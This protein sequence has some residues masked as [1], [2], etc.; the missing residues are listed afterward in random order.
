M[1]SL[2]IMLIKLMHNNHSF[3]R[4]YLF[5]I[6]LKI[7]L[8]LIINKI[9]NFIKIYS[10]VMKKKYKYIKN[11]EKVLSLLLTMNK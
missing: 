7:N 3:K 8:K 10:M 9:M 1:I 4:K 11:I 2:L 6:K 5:K